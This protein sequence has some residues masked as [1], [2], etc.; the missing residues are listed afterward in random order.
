MLQIQA[1]HERPHAPQPLSY[2]LM[3]FSRFPLSKRDSKSS[4]VSCG[5]SKGAAG[6]ESGPGAPPTR[7]RVKQEAWS[8]VGKQGQWWGSGES[9]GTQGCC[10]CSV[11][12][13]VVDSGALLLAESVHGLLR[14]HGWA[15]GLWFGGDPL[16]EGMTQ[17][18][19]PY[20]QQGS[21]TGVRWGGQ[22]EHPLT[23]VLNCLL[24]DFTLHR[25]AGSREGEWS[26]WV[27]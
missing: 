21:S 19:M 2:T 27:S 1:C 9:R 12:W 7:A 22:L 10:L 15:E 23:D 20:T 8:A 6:E 14:A 13:A 25:P 17:R 26:L 4:V 3:A 24:D 11:T 16:W 5:P 18:Q